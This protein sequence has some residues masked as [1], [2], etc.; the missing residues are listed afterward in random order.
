MNHPICRLYAFCVGIIALTLAGCAGVTIGGIGTGDATRPKTLVV[1]DF[2][3][4]SDVVA[5]DR[6]YTTR[7]ERKVGTFPTYERKQ[8]TNARVNDEIVATIVTTLKE[9]GLDAQPGSEES[10]TLQDDVVLITGRLQGAEQGNAAKNKRI[11]FGAGRG[12]VMADM[13]LSRFTSGSKN[14]LLSFTVH[15]QAARKRD[16]GG[17]KQTADR[18][19]AIDATLA[20]EGT[21]P[22]KLSVD[23]E[24]QARQLGTAIGERIVAFARENGWLAKAEEGASQS[25]KMPGRIP[26]QR[27]APEQQVSKPA[28]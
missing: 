5:L 2:V 7:L 9:A 3:F 11:G 27:P 10:L 16:A 25:E 21:P 24:G 14:Q 22:V 18:N 23:T 19:A 28:T 17:R 13:A 15:A 8:R 6:S 4:S 26:P 1:S 12:G 20:A